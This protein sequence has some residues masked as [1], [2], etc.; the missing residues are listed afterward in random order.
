MQLVASEAYMEPI[1]FYYWHILE[2][3]SK[4]VRVFIEEINKKVDYIIEHK[5]IMK[6]VETILISLLGKA[7]LLETS[8]YQSQD[9]VESLKSINQKLLVN[10][11]N[12]AANSGRLYKE[13]KILKSS[14]ERVEKELSLTKRKLRLLKYCNYIS[15]PLMIVH[16]EKL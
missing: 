7:K 3:A 13:I 1:S 11:S 10:V 2:S 9:E 6:L 4:T 15:Y 14:H 16:E 12:F 5:N 8:N